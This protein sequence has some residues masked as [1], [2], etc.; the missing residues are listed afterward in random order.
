MAGGHARH[1]RVSLARV[2]Q[3]SFLSALSLDMFCPEPVLVK[4]MIGFL[5]YQM[6]QNRVAFSV[7]LARDPNELGADP[8]QQRLHNTQ[9]MCFNVITSI[10]MN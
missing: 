5:V 3:I 10:M 8:P 9:H 6:M 1:R 4:M 2:S 7:Y